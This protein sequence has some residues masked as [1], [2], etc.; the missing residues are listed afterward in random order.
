MD[1]P[2]TVSHPKVDKTWKTG[3]NG[4]HFA[5]D[6]FKCIYLNENVVLLFIF[7]RVLFL[8]D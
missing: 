3:Q 7:H 5:D 8:M 2:T 6:I 4:H 1:S